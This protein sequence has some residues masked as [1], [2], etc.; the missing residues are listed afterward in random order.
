MEEDEEDEDGAAVGEEV[1][2]GEVDDEGDV[3]EEMVAWSEGSMQRLGS[4]SHS[5]SLLPGRT[6][7]TLL[8]ASRMRPPRWRWW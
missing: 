8:T 1:G 3:A 7:L 5:S 2:G 6:L 4:G